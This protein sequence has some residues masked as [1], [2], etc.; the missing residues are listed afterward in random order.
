MQR[1]HRGV[2]RGR[3]SCEKPSHHMKR[4]EAEQ[5]DK[6]NSRLTQPHTR[7]K[8]RG[9]DFTTAVVNPAAG[10]LWLHAATHGH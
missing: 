9:I 6:M 10:M 7:E 1:G 8:H 2:P 4:K 5:H 3:E